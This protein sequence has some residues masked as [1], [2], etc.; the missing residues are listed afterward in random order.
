MKITSSHSAIESF[1]TYNSSILD[2]DIFESRDLACS[3]IKKETSKVSKESWETQN[4]SVY[5][6]WSFKNHN[7][8][9]SKIKELINASLICPKESYTINNVKYED[10]TASLKILVAFVSESDESKLDDFIFRHEFKNFVKSKSLDDTIYS[11]ITSQQSDDSGIHLD[12]KGVVVKPLNEILNTAIFDLD[13][14]LSSE[15]PSSDRLSLIRR[16]MLNDTYRKEL[17]SNID[18]RFLDPKY[19]LLYPYFHAKARFCGEL[20]AKPKNKIGTSRLEAFGELL[21]LES[22][23]I[24]N[25][26]EFSAI[27][28]LGS[29]SETA[30]DQTPDLDNLPCIGREPFKRMYLNDVKRYEIKLS[31]FQKYFRQ[32]DDIEQ[33]E[34]IQYDPAINYRDFFDDERIKPYWLIED[35]ITC[36]YTNLE[37]FFIIVSMYSHKVNAQDFEFSYTVS[38]NGKSATL[39]AVYSND[40]GKSRP[41]ELNALLFHDIRY[42]LERWSPFHYDVR[43]YFDNAFEVIEY[44]ICQ[45]Q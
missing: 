38:C 25:G 15:S 17:F 31:K 32:N 3:A 33:I 5:V 28:K 21:N 13:R 40:A 18:L 41:E 24:Q 11:C 19:V 43:P 34:T 12:F 27:F 16:Y 22:E 14:L 37:Y 20:F 1:S 23:N 26:L 36:E 42:R 8:V 6:F 29:Q 44:D 2:C 30:V 4:N 9:F 45:K 10:Q 39:H 7:F 35:P